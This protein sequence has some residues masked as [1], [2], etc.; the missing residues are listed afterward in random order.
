VGRSQT[1]HAW[2]GAPPFLTNGGNPS[3]WTAGAGLDYAFTRNVF[4]RIEYR[5]TDL[6]T[7]S[8]IDVPTNSG[9]S[10]NKVTISDVRAGIAYKFGPDWFLGTF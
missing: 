3:G 1:G 9:E 5:Y 6:G 10:G 2:L 7:R 8:F 4:G